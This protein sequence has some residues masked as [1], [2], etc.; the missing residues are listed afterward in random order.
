MEFGKGF[1]DQLDILLASPRDIHLN[2]DFTAHIFCL[3]NLQRK[4]QDSHSQGNMTAQVGWQKFD[5]QSCY[6]S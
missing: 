3:V 5:T 1:D 6:T 2:D 4:M